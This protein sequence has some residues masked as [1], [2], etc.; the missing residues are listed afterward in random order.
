MDSVNGITKKHSI[1]HFGNNSM[2]FAI[3]RVKL[4]QKSGDKPKFGLKVKNVGDYP[5]IKKNLSIFRADI[6]KNGSEISDAKIAQVIKGIF[7]NQL[8]KLESELEHLRLRRELFHRFYQ[9]LTHLGF[10]LLVSE[11]LESPAAILL[12]RMILDLIANDHLSW[13]S[14]LDGKMFMD[15]EEDRFNA[16]RLHD[17]YDKFMMYSYSFHEVALSWDKVRLKDIENMIEKESTIVDLWLEKI[18][19]IPRKQLS[20]LD[21]DTKTININQ[22][23]T[24]WEIISDMNKTI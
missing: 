13:E 16:R 8:D 18:L 12:N 2:V 19:S 23:M 10:I 14:A 7:T 9:L 21:I 17:L 4:P 24:D 5:E 3:D 1:W 11:P 22:G 20:E 15:K 6:S